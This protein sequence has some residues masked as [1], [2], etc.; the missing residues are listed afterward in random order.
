MKNFFS[1][2]I[3]VGA[4]LGLGLTS[5]SKSTPDLIND[6][7]NA[8]KEQL[9]ATGRGDSNAALKASE[10]ASK[11]AK[12]LEGRDL[13]PEEKEQ[14]MD[15]AMEISETAVSTGMKI[16]NDAVDQAYDGMEDNFSE[17]EQEDTEEEE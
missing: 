15:A 9:E 5:C 2:M 16:M 1:I 6:Y 8:V 13:T 4:L 10:K 17:P 7:K 12:E 11:I 14:V 3:V